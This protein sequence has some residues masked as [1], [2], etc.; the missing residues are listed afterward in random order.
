MYGGF[1][2]W[3][4]DHAP[5]R[6]KTF[7]GTVTFSPDNTPCKYYEINRD[8][9]VDVSCNGELNIAPFTGEYDSSIKEGD[10]VEVKAQIIDPRGIQ[11]Y[12]TYDIRNTGQY[13]KKIS[14]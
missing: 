4:Y 2:Y 1:R 5:G 3:Q 7:T 6:T 11:G 12:K 14:N 9:L 8:T 13:V 10:I